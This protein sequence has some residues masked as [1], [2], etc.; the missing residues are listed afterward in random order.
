VPSYINGDDG[1]NGKERIYTED[2]KKRMR[3]AIN[4]ATSLQE[5]AKLEKEF[6]EGRI[7]AYVLE[8]GDA[9]ETT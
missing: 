9:M 3:A 4:A 8:A 5:M 6:S 2:E 7:P 1:E